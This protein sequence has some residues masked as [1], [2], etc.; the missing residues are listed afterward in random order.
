MGQQSMADLMTRDEIDAVAEMFNICFGAAANKLADI[1]K[2]PSKISKPQVNPASAL[3]LK[4]AFSAPFFTFSFRCMPGNVP[5]ALFVDA[6][7]CGKLV[8]SIA[9]QELDFAAQPAQELLK[10]NLSELIGAACKTLGA[11][12]KK[13]VGANDFVLK[14]TQPLENDQGD[15]L[16]KDFSGGAIE[17]K[18]V[19]K[20]E[21]IFDGFLYVVIPVEFAKFLSS[22]FLIVISEQVAGVEATPDAPGRVTVKETE[23]LEQVINYCSRIGNFALVEKLKAGLTIRLA[24]KKICFKELWNAQGGYIINFSKS[25]DDPIEVLFGNTIFARAQVVENNDKLG[26]RITEVIK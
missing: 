18:M 11:T 3:R 7:L 23:R 25:V 13:D 16:N 19:F 22:E 8:N 24:H 6:P 15:I 17:V 1:V 2:A 9:G 12:L 14:L 21:G 4:E 5:W 26:A 10:G 20:A